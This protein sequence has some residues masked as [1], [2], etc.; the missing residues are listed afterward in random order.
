MLLFFFIQQPQ[1]GTQD[2]KMKLF[3]SGKMSLTVTV[4]KT[5]YIQGDLVMFVKAA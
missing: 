4:E 5:G 1:S 3:G 2:K